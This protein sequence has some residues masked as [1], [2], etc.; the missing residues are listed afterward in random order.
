MYSNAFN[1]DKAKNVLSGNGLIE[2]QS[3]TANY[4]QPYSAHLLTL[5]QITNFRLFQIERVC[6]RQFLS[7]MKM[8][9]SSHIG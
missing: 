5:P 1:F 6:R 8:T 3:F 7:L 9:E 4:W 2:N